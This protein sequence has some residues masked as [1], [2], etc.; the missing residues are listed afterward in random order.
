LI[1]KLSANLADFVNLGQKRKQKTKKP[2]KKSQKSIKNPQKHQKNTS[3]TL[4]NT[5]NTPKNSS[6]T[7]KKP[8]NLYKTP[9]HTRFRA[10][11]ALERANSSTPFSFCPRTPSL[12][13]LHLAG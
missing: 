8:K 7:L 11:D 5:S 6:K 3:K 4:K 1:G 2:P 10:H 12:P 13:S 9:P